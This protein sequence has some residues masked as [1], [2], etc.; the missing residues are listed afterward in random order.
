MEKKNNLS[1]S[2][3]AGFLILIFLISRIFHFFQDPSN[4]QEFIYFI[5]SLGICLGII[6][7]GFVFLVIYSRFFVRSYEAKL[8]SMSDEY[9]VRCI[10]EGMNEEMNTHNEGKPHTPQWEEL[11]SPIYLLLSRTNFGVSLRP[12]PKSYT[13][14]SISADN[15]SRYHVLS[16]DRAGPIVLPHGFSHLYYIL[17][18]KGGEAHLGRQ[19]E[20]S[21][22]LPVDLGN[23]QLEIVLIYS[24]ILED[25]N[26]AQIF[27][28]DRKLRI[29]LTVLDRDGQDDEET[30]C[31]LYNDM[32]EFMNPPDT[33]YDDYEYFRSRPIWY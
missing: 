2:K 30:T 29:K 6:I 1:Y 23:N 4:V 33:S 14:E 24:A 18:Y 21:G 32:F 28:M 25:G 20:Q 19:T 8:T 17:S 31:K 9:P 10:P 26:L 11:I 16:S 12:I 13:W 5:E 15:E 3:V 27:K 7:L 22:P